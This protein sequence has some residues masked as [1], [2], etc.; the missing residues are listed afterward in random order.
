VLTDDDLPVVTSSG[1]SLGAEDLE[2]IADAF[3]AGF[4]LKTWERRPRP[5]GRPRLE[6][7]ATEDSPRIAVRIPASLRT[8]VQ[9]R[10]AREGKTVSEVVRGLLED[11]AS[12]GR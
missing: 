5:V 7:Q 3:E 9:R 6:L 4:D 12:P 11:Y 8:R 1:R 10:A 2:R